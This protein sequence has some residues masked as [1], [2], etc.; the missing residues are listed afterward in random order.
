[1]HI[2]PYHRRKSW[3]RFIAGAVIGAVLAYM[4]YLYIYGSLYE[5]LLQEN[6]QIQAELDEV[7]RHNEALLEDNEELDKRS[8]QPL[9]VETIQ[10]KISNGSELKD[11]LIIHQLEEMMKEEINHLVGKDLSSIAGSDELLI[12]TI[13]NKSFTIDGFTYSF[14]IEKL[15]ISTDVKLTAEAE[16]SN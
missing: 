6:Y 5:Q 3:Q 7:K 2:P 13:E 4:V 1:M 14:K 10:V 15:I 8:N 11:E 9:T 12:S 16:L